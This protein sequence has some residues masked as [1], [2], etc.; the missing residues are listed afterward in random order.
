MGPCFEEPTPGWADTW[1]GP[2][3]LISGFGNGSLRSIMCE[4]KYVVDIVPVDIV[5]NQLIVTAWITATT[6]YNELMVYNCVT[7]KQN[8]I[9]L[10]EFFGYVLK[11]IRLHP[12]E[13]LLW[14]PTMNLCTN[15]H[16]NM[17]HGF[18]AQNIPANSYDLF[19]RFAGKRPM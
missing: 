8:P 17:L 12:L 18:L 13:G 3:G 15:R 7:R 10:G 1:N 16:L 2:T 14:Y 11:Y 5:I 6:K 9:T 4:Q 19:L